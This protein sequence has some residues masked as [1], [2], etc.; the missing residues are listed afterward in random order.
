LLSCERSFCLSAASEIAKYATDERKIIVATT[1]ET[2]ITA[3]GLAK[4]ASA[5]MMVRPAAV[6][7]RTVTVV[8]T[9]FAMV[10]A[11][12]KIEPFVE[13]RIATGLTLG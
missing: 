2:Q 6:I 3:A 7:P 9:A 13:C 1:K 12:I 10:R 8:R 11:V 4:P 5:I